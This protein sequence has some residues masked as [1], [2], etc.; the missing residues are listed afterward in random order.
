MEK[1]ISMLQVVKVSL[2]DAVRSI[3]EDDSLS[4][5]VGASL[6]QMLLQVQNMLVN[7]EHTNL[8]K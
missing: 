1:T 7:I 6:Y 3:E 5:G 8:K 4:I 2:L